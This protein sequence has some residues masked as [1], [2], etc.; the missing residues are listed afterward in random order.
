MGF[1]PPALSHGRNHRRGKMKRTAGAFILL[2]SLG[3]GCIS[4]DRANT[5][6]SGFNRVS[7][8][9]EIPGIK[10]PMGQPIALGS[11]GQAYLTSSDTG[12]VTPANYTARSSSNGIQQTGLLNKGAGCT[13]CGSSH[14]FG[15]GGGGSHHIGGPF[16]G[17]QRGGEI[18]PSYPNFNGQGIVPVPG[19][20]PPG[21]VAAVGAL[22]PFGAL[23]PVN[24]RTSVKFTEPA[25]MNVT[26]YGPKGLN[27]IPLT[28]PARYNFAQGGIYRLKLTNIVKNPG[29][30]L[31]PT[32]EVYPVTPKTVTFLAHSSVPVAF[33][34]S[35]IE[36]VS[37][38][39]FLT[40][41]IYLPDRE[42]QDLSTLAGP[43]EI[44]SSP[45]EPGMD[46]LIEAQKRGTI[47]LVIR[48][49]NINLEVPNSPAMDAPN[50]YMMQGP[51]PIPKPIM[52]GAPSMTPIP[53]GGTPKLMPMGIEGSER[54]MELSP[55]PKTVDKKMELSPLPKKN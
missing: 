52:P 51:P 10:G 1:E 47:L 5:P 55:L 48:M 32:L 12:G 37:A 38:G 27:E 43:A 31:Y 23:G 20:G 8:A 24:S 54:K 17:H 45:L 35:D 15:G 29:L 28:T 16:Q 40:K 41:V 9:K 34:E 49:G 25:G 4:A 2:A 39:N 50:P 26:W 53:G 36:Q 30:E 3:G 7:Y 14:G 13:T 18:A 46:P 11:N 6:T 33:T 44:V 19:M 42:Y 21:A 22:P